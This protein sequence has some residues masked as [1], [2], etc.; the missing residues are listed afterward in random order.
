M[1]KRETRDSFLQRKKY[2]IKKYCNKWEYRKK[3]EQSSRASIKKT[4]AHILDATWQEREY[5]CAKINTLQQNADF[6]LP[7]H[8]YICFYIMLIKNDAFVGSV[9]L[10]EEFAPGTEKSE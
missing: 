2:C 4:L 3:K 8:H 6:I 7:I 10:L 1:L 5:K 9:I